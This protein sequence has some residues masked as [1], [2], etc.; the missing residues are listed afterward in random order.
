MTTKRRRTTRKQARPQ[1]LEEKA[2]EEI[3][4]TVATILLIAATVIFVPILFAPF[5]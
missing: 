5:K 1:T 4:W 2:R 3:F